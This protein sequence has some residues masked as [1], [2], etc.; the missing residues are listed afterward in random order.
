MDY[1]ED[2]AL[3]VAVEL[4]QVRLLE[5]FFGIRVEQARLALGYSLGEPTALMAAGVFPMADL[6]RVPLALADDCADL[7]DEVTLGVLFSRGPVL[8]FD[9]VRQLCL[10]ISQQGKGIIDISTYLSPNSLLLMGQNN[11]LGRLEDKV[12]EAFPRQVYL[13]KNQHRWPPLHTPITWLRNIPN[14]AAVLLQTTTGG[15]QAPRLPI[16]SHVT[17]EESYGAFNSR[18]LLHRW[19]DQPQRLWDVV[20]RLL[21]TGIETVVHVGPSPNLL[22]ATLQRLRNNIEA[23]MNGHG[24]GSLGRRTLSRLVRRPWLSRLLPSN[25]ALLRARFVQQVVL[26]DWLLER[27]FE[28]R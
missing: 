13:R 10:E 18:E 8:D 19:V 26:E 9:V 16:L 28:S 11:S 27:P 17:G 4:A 14:R 2:V 5:E 24:L 20:Y 3:I 6:L 22:P 15:F 1:A 25:T 23:Q 12:H 21:A 7:A